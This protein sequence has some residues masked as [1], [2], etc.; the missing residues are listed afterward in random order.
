MKYKNRFGLKTIVVSWILF[1]LSSANGG[2]E[3]INIPLVVHEALRKNVA[4]VNRMQEPVTLGLPFPKGMLKEKDG[5]PLLSLQGT[6]AYQFRTLKRWLDGSVQWALIDFQADVKA[7]KMNRDIKVVSGKGNSPGWLAR[8]M[9]ESI[10]IDTGVMR[11]TINKRGFNLFESIVIDSAEM[12]SNAS[13]GIVLSDGEG[14]EYLAS[15][16]KDIKVTIEENGPLRAVIKAEGSHVRDNKRLMNFTMRMHFYKGKSRVK[17]Y[18]TL[19]N[20]SKGQIEHAFI[21]SLSLVTGLSL[22]KDSTV[23]ASGHNGIVEGTLHGSDDNITFYQAVSDFPQEYSENFYWHAPIPPDSKRESVMGF[24]QEGY[25]IKK[26]DYILAAGKRKEYPDL[27]FLDISDTR[28]VGVTLGI[29]FAA[30][31][32]PKGIQANGDGI[33]EVGLWPKDNE[34]GY[35]IRYGSHNTF[36]IMYDFHGRKNDP[37]EEMK[38][39]QYPLAAKASVEWYNE[40][41]NGIYPLYHFVSFNEETAYLKSRGWEYLVGWRTP[42]MN[43]IRHSYWG[44]GGFLNQHDF[45][46][47]SLVNFLR[48]TENTLKAGEYYLTADAR[49]NY[50][51][52]WAVLHS[53]DYDSSQFDFWPEKNNEKAD[54]AKVIFEIEHMHWYG[55]P[56]YYYLTGDERIREAILDWGEVIKGRSKKHELIVYDRFFGWEMYSLAAMYE[57]ADDPLYMRMADQIFQRLLSARFN[58]KNPWSNIFIDWN[59][60]F[61][62]R[63]DTDLKPGLMMGYIIFDGLYNYYLQMDDKNLLKERV[64]DVLEGLSEFMYRE[65]YFEGTK[66]SKNHWAFWLPYI[67]NIKDKNKSNHSYR[68]ILESFYVNLAPYLLTG[69]TKWLERM[70]KI[71][72]SSAWDES[73]V[74]GGFGYMDHPGLQS[75]LYQK[76]YPRRDDTS[77]QAVNDLSAELNGANIIL[78]WTAPSEAIR[79]QIKFSNK[80][81]VES[82]GF[83]PDKKVYEYDPQE[84]ANWWAGEN[85]P[86]EPNPGIAG[87]RQNYIVKG[88]KRGHYYFAIRSWDASNNRS[89]ISNLAD[90]IIK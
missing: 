41:V 31:W 71:I 15:N 90:I 16:D 59:R 21:K 81:F 86:D 23:K 46:R 62:M 26:N 54:L 56:L 55:L 74:W 89:R 35:W 82:L 69:D 80:K 20:A 64:A 87:S 24:V 70:D 13:K 33:V 51:A 65:P 77:L 67:Y 38:K 22:T 47:I 58:E 48:E 10:V 79:Y 42:T 39:F 78:K 45:A 36:E 8:D 9:R 83:D 17:V 12:L 1:L 43:I 25:W 52:D 85:I 4:G 6:D 61:V 40:N 34:A 14:Q 84:Y 29:R 73:G 49:F 88:L 68:L 32:W 3:G 30:G 7:G 44:K 72:K 57:F 37:A 19:R 75:I 53:D 60:G 28:G 11:T 18:Y 2:A 66:G 50:N 63:G 27:T 5:M 76:L